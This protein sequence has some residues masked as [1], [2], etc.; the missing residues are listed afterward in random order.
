MRLSELEIYQRAR[1][2]YVA[3]SDAWTHEQMTKRKNAKQ[4]RIALLAAIEQNAYLARVAEVS[5]AKQSSEKKR[6]GKLHEPR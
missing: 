3:T 2:D 4:K 6:K 5:R 1:G